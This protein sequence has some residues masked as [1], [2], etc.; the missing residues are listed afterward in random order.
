[1]RHSTTFDMRQATAPVRWCD[2][3]DPIEARYSQRLPRWFVRNW[4]R[5][6]IEPKRCD[7]A[8]EVQD[9]LSDSILDEWGVMYLARVPVLVAR[10]FGGRYLP[11]FAMR[12]HYVAMR[13]GGVWETDGTNILWRPDPE[14][15]P[16]VLYRGGRLTCWG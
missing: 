12:C 15:L 10:P 7:V 14:S 5:S 6:S 1:M 16:R 2:I 13:G 9:V 8:A 4:R 3:P 11:R